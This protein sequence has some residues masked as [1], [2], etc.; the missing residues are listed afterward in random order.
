MAFFC[1]CYTVRIF[2]VHFRWHFC[3][4]FLACDFL[5]CKIY[6]CPS[7][8]VQTC[9]IGK[10]SKYF[11]Q[12]RD[13]I[14]MYSNDLRPVMKCTLSS[15]RDVSLGANNDDDM[16]S[17]RMAFVRNLCRKKRL[18]S[19]SFLLIRC[20]CINRIYKSRCHFSS[21]SYHIAAYTRNALKNIAFIWVDVPY[22]QKKKS[23][24]CFNSVSMDDKTETT[25]PATTFVCSE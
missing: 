7:C 11:H 3:L 25:A 10:K 22:I 18:S 21:S 24:Y 17:H 16:A 2:C 8:N 14:Y 13:N 1:A 20:A 19:L 23:T 15:V 9:V 6:S 12:K 4:I 5:V